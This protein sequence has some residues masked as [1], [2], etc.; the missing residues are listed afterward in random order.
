MANR[1][2]QKRNEGDII[3]G[4]I[5]IR[6]L[7][8]RLWEMK[9]KCGEIFISQPSYTSGRCKKCG[10]EKAAKLNRKHGESPKHGRNATR[11]YEIWTGMKNRCYNPNN[12]SYYAYGERGIKVCAEWHEYLKFKE[13]AMNNGYSDNLSI[14]RID[15]NCD[16]EPG[17][18]RWATQKEQMRN[19][20]K[21]HILKFNGKE[22]TIAEWSEEIGINYHTLKQRINKYGF[23]VEEALT[24]PV[25]E[26]RKNKFN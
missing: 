4:A 20:R 11:L 23:S 15:V 18:C 12:H 6:R 16:Y 5:L 21:N 25:G 9:C 22:K 13:W 10:I 17:N 19:T 14:D 8:S 7:N 1:K 24:I 26:K 2:Y 3:N